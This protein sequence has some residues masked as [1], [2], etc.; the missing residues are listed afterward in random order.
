MQARE[1]DTR[2][3]AGSGA[4][5]QRS[6]RGRIRQPS[7]VSLLRRIELGG[8]EAPGGSTQCKDDAARKQ[9][10]PE[11]LKNGLSPAGVASRLGTTVRTVQPWRRDDRDGLKRVRKKTGR[12]SKLTGILLRRLARQSKRGAQEHGC[13]DEHWTP[14]RIA[15][16]IWVTGFG[17]NRRST[18]QARRPWHISPATMLLQRS[19]TAKK[20]NPDCCPGLFIG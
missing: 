4:R 13:H 3:C 1:G 15:H 10:E 2:V 9:R 19:V 6:A 5:Q 17:F 8:L 12:P 20:K 14:D 11:L 18:P 7:R 16:L